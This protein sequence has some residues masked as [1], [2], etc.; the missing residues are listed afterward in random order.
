[1]HIADCRHI[2]VVKNT[3]N[4]SVRVSFDH[5]IVVVTVTGTVEAGMPELEIVEESKTDE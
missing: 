5:D 4:E 2:K 1:M 3:E